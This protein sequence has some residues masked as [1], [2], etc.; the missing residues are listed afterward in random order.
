MRCCTFKMAGEAKRYAGARKQARADG[1]VFIYL[2]VFPLAGQYYRMRAEFR[3]QTRTMAMT[4]YHI[5]D[6]NKIKAVHP[7]G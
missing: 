6:R 1:T 7:R 3:R 5:I 2:E 4:S